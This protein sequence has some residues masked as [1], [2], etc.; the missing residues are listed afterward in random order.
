[1]LRRIYIIGEFCSHG[2]HDQGQTHLRKQGGNYYSK[3][4]LITLKHV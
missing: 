2:I 4:R 1:M 3:V